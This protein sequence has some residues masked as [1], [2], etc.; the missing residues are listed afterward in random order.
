MQS[1]STKI[2]YIHYPYELGLIVELREFLLEDGLFEAVCSGDQ[3]FGSNY[4]M[5]NSWSASMA[6]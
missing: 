6:Q 1:L 5:F 2:P 3:L 4:K